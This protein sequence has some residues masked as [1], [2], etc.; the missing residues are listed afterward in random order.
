MKCREAGVRKGIEILVAYGGKVLPLNAAID[1][2][3]FLIAAVDRDGMPSAD[4]ACG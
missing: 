4:K 3:G 2:N 1:A